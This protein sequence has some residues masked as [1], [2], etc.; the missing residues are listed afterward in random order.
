MTM[1]CAQKLL[2]A[3][4]EHRC[5]EQRDLAETQCVLRATGVRRAQTHKILMGVGMKSRRIR[6]LVPAG[7]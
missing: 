1:A 2:A 3:E 5:C 4:A 6:S 7:R